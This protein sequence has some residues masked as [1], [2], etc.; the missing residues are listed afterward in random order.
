[1]KPRRVWIDFLVA[2]VL[3][4]GGAVVLHLDGT[5]DAPTPLT[6]QDWAAEGVRIGTSEADLVRLRG[7]GNGKVSLLAICPPS[8]FRL[9]YSTGEE[10]LLD[11]STRSVKGMCVNRLQNSLGLIL[12]GGDPVTALHALGPP[13]S[14]WCNA[15]GIGFF[16]YPDQGLQ[17]VVAHCIMQLR[18]ADSR[19]PVPPPYA[20]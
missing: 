8:D 16:Q 18:L 5:T 15:D 6:L 13:P 1:M 19:I 2:V 9:A 11:R 17:I 10:F 12:K 20:P 7:P 3:I 14:K 4:A